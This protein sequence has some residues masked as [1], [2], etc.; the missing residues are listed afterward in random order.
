[1]KDY[2]SLLELTSPS[3]SEEIKKAYRKLAMKH[4]PDRGGDEEHFKKI[5]Q[6]YEFLSDPEKKSMIDAGHDPASSKNPTNSQD[7]HFDSGNF[8]DIFSHFGFNFHHQRQQVNKSFNFV[9]NVT[10]EDVLVGKEIGADIT[11]PDNSNKTIKINIPPGVLHR[12]QIKYHGLGDDSIPGIPAGD[13]IVNVNVLPHAIFHREGNHLIY[14]QSISVWDAILGSTLTIETL[15]KKQF[16]ISIPSG[17]QHGT[18]L[19]CRAEGMPILRSSDKGNLLIK[20]STSI[21]TNLSVEQL[22]KIKEI[23]DGV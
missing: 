15:S 21:P 3:S 22:Q 11:L 5:N 9:V 23:K 18:I 12:Q 4:H 10:L 16:Q 14:E 20:I 7:F 8:N 2:Y 1:M 19:S 13:L 6:A 17:T